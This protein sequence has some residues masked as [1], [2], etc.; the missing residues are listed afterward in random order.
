MLCCRP[1]SPAACKDAPQ[2]LSR[3]NLLAR[4]FWRKGYQQEAGCKQMLAGV[5]PLLL[6]FEIISS[7]R[8]GGFEAFQKILHIINLVYAIFAP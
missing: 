5:S 8:E 6:L 1:I 3:C 4:Q 7:P 2:V